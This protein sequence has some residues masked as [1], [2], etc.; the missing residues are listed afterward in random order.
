MASTTRDIAIRIN[1]D[2][3]LIALGVV[4]IETGAIPFGIVCLVLS[5][6][7][8]YE[9]NWWNGIAYDSYM[10]LQSINF[11]LD[12][13]I[14]CFTLLKTSLICWSFS[15]SCSSIFENFAAPVLVAVAGWQQIYLPFY[16]S[17]DLCSAESLQLVIVRGTVPTEETS[18]EHIS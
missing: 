15:S 10:F 6:V 9:L 18:Q 5:E 14:I 13:P 12:Q 1:L 7:S 2:T 11:H 16:S 17:L 3:Q 8:H 4:R